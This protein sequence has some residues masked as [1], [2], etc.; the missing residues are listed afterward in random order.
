LV[1]ELDDAKRRR[2]VLLID[3]GGGTVEHVNW[4]L[5]RGYQLHCKDY[6]GHRV[7]KLANSVRERFTEGQNGICPVQER[8][9]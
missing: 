7:E 3:A 8:H 2:T 5:E 9:R 4:L 6:S 1:L